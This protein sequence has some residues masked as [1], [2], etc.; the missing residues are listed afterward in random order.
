MVEKIEIQKIM[1]PVSSAG[2]K[3]IKRKNG[4][5]QQKNF[6]RHLQEEEK[7]KKRD[8]RQA[9]EDPEIVAHREEGNEVTAMHEKGG[10]KSHINIGTDDNTQGR[11]IDILV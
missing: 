11:L 8:A 10:R 4:N 3:K 5:I 9:L 7:E 2:V 1:P 6:G